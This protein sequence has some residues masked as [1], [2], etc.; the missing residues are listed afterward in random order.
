VTFI[1]CAIRAYLLKKLTQYLVDNSTSLKKVFNQMSNITI[2]SSH[3]GY[4]FTKALTKKQKQM[5]SAFDAALDIVK[6][7]KE[8][9]S[10]LK[11]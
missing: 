5:L 3:N 10:T 1:A 8:N 9:T 7:I 4:R 2:L 11:S 6:S